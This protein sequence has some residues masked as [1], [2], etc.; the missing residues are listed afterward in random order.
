M[1]VLYL[2]RY[3]QMYSSIRIR[4]SALTASFRVPA[5]VSH[6]LTLT[7]PPLSTIFGLLSASVGRWV[8][9]K[10]VDWIAY[11]FVYET[12]TTDLEAIINVQRKENEGSISFGSRNVIQREFLTMP[13]LTL[14]LP[15]MWEE[16]FRCPRYTLLLGRTQDVACVESIEHITLQHVDVGK[17]KGVLLPYHIVTQNHAPAWLQNLPIIFTDEPKRT[18]LGMQIFGV[19]D[20]YRPATLTNVTHWLVRDADIDMEVPIYTQEWMLNAVQ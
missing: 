3:I 9:P 12:K 18:P 15:P 10:E 14:Y 7:V 5:F 4:I 11:S 16:H 8:Y 13:S 2:W 1:I 6:Q 20:A 17:V 19:V